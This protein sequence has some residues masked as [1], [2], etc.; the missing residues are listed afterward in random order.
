MVHPDVHHQHVLSFDFTDFAQRHVI[1]K[2]YKVIAMRYKMLKSCARRARQKEEQASRDHENRK[3][4][5]Q[6]DGHQPGGHAGASLPRGRLR[7]LPRL[8]NLATGEGGYAKHQEQQQ[9][10]EKVEAGRN[11][12]RGQQFQKRDHLKEQ[13][14]AIGVPRQ[15]LHHCDEEDHMNRRWDEGARDEKVVDWIKADVGERDRGDD[16]RGRVEMHQAGY[17]QRADDERGRGEEEGGRVQIA[18]SRDGQEARG[19]QSQE[20]KLEKLIHR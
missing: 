7:S 1:R 8:T 2:A 20:R 14:V 9:E 15:D 3:R 17:H 13:V 16:G 19:E 18:R 12:A 5:A 10:N 4:N 6:D 11:N